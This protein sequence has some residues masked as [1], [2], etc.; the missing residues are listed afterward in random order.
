M[1]GFGTSDSTFDAALAIVEYVGATLRKI[2]IG[3][4]VIKHFEDIEHDSEIRNTTVALE[5]EQ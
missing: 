4:S 2:P 3:P 5:T 1:P